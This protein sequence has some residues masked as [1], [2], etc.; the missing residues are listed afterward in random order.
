MSVR[1]ASGTVPSRVRKPSATDCG[2]GA[3]AGREPRR[4]DGSR[5]SRRWRRRRDGGRASTGAGEAG[6]PALRSR[7]GGGE[8][9]DGRRRGGLAVARPELPARRGRGRLHRGRGRPAR[10]GLVDLLLEVGLAAGGGFL[11]AR[12]RGLPAS[13]GAEGREAVR[14]GR[15]DPE[16]LLDRALDRIAERA[17]GLVDRDDRVD[18]AVGRRV[19]L[20]ELVVHP[21]DGAADLVDHGHH[22]DA[23]RR[24]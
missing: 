1:A 10:V 12:G 19:D 7:R 15:R 21:V 13:L 16:Q 3:G 24:G 20:V 2:R 6:P 8:G 17:H 11:R 4:Q 9:V 22:L 14:D 5:R 18:G 23:R